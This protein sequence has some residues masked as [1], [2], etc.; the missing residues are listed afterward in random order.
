[1]GS[2]A[3]GD[4]FRGTGGDHLPAGVAPF[5][6][7]VDHVVGGLDYIQMVLD[8]QHR[9]THVD[10]A[11][12]RFE[13]ALDIGQVQAGGRLVQDVH[14]VPGT[15]KL[16]QLRCDLDPL[17]LA[18]GK[19]GCRLPQRQV[20]QPEIVEHT[21]FFADGRLIG[22][23]AHAFFD[24]HVQD[25]SDSLAAQR[26]LERLSVEARPFA[27]A[28]QYLDVGH[29]V[30]LCRDDALALALFAAASLDV[31]AEASREAGS[32]CQGEGVITTQLSSC[33]TSRYCAARAK[34]R[35]ST[36]RREV[37]LRGQTIT[38]ILN[39]SVEEG[40]SFFT[41]EPAVREKNKCA[42]RSRAGLLLA[43]GQSATTLSGARPRGSSGQRA[44]R[45]TTC[46]AHRVHPGRADHRPAPGRLERLLE[47]LNRL[48]DVGHTVLLIEHHLDVIKT[49]DYVIDLGPEERGRWSPPVPLKK[50]PPARFPHRTLPQAPPEIFIFGRFSFRCRSGCG[51]SGQ[52]TLSPGPPNTPPETPARPRPLGLWGTQAVL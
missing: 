18:P 22:K 25:I 45:L 52:P 14:G 32:K 3:G 43:L 7:Q 5:G 4:F 48:V 49:A 11:V 13:Q 2:G 27:R 23:K 16:A 26:N 19:C 24:G 9:V 8:Q 41:D 21:Y 46:P 30:E 50:S 42:R 34:G 1:M 36:E 10:Q 44:E 51:F 38:D 31:E 40:V 39:M 17:G 37:T 20:A 33:P 29:E 28:A 47:S 35:A 12:Q 15:L 6:S